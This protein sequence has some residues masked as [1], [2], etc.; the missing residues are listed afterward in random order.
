MEVINN[1]Q[2]GY[3]RF[4]IRYGLKLLQETHWGVFRMDNYTTISQEN[5]NKRVDVNI[6]KPLLKV[7]FELHNEDNY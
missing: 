3:L 7:N 4:D 5:G 6:L 1:Q 2:I